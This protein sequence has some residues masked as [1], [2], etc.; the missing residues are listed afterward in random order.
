MQLR[1]K[2]QFKK[3]ATQLTPNQQ[4][5]LEERLELFLENPHH[6]LLRNHQLNGELAD[7]RSINIS[8]DLRALYFDDGDSYV[9]ITVGTHSQLYK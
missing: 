1:F 2:K 9:F 7:I 5:Q 8:G 4:N 6:P 3:T